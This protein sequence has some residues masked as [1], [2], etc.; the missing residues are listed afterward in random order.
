M[1]KTVE[2][3]TSGDRIADVVTTIAP[4][5]RERLIGQ[6]VL[7]VREYPARVWI[8]LV[9]APSVPIHPGHVVEIDTAPITLDKSS[10]GL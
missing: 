9:G 5:D 6:T 7:A 3:L 8:D 4:A 1:T 10:I 2:T